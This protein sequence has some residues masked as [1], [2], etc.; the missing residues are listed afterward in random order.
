MK[1]DPKSLEF[2]IKVC[3]LAYPDLFDLR[4]QVLNHLYCILG[5]G[6]S[7]KDGAILE[8]NEDEKLSKV[9]AMLME[10]A[11]EEEI[12]AWVFKKDEERFGAQRRAFE[13]ELNKLKSLGVDIRPPRL[14]PKDVWIYPVFE[15][16]AIM[17]I[18]DDVRPDWLDGAEEVV[19]LIE[20]ASSIEAKET[21]RNR[22]FVPII[23]ERISVL[24]ARSGNE[25]HI[26]RG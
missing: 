8:H 26:S 16:C 11:P 23:R 20:T 7:W 21:E 25:S 13:E 24:K 19:K 1:H 18:P 2:Q 14:K 12:K 9:E 22:S 10:G 3:L 15:G 17:K 5:N 4:G 6:C